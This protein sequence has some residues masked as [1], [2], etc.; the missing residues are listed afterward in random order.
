MIYSPS[1]WSIVKIA[2]SNN[3]TTYKVIGGWKVGYLYGDSWRVNSGIAMINYVGN[4]YEFIGHSGSIYSCHKDNERISLVMAIPI[5]L[6]ED[7]AERSG[8]KVEIIKFN[9]MEL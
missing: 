9:Q 8:E 3:K 4:S 1:S 6:M 2:D 7:A 5:K